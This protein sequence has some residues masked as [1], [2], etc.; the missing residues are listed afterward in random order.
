[1]NPLTEMIEGATDSKWS[2]CGI[3]VRDHREWKVLEAIGPVKTTDLDEWINRSR[4]NRFSVFRFR[5]EDL[6]YIPQFIESAQTYLG[7]PYDIQYEWDDSKIYCSELLYKAFDRVSGIKLGKMQKVEELN[8]RP[9][10]YLI[11]QLNQGKLP[12]ERELITPRAITESSEVIQ[13][14]PE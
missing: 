8:W 9:Y 6:K 2:H 7:L 14:Y 4:E 1:M 3:V 12:R 13:V 10:E 11:R 5:S